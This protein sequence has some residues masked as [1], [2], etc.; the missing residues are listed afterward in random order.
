[1]EIVAII[2][3]RYGS[4]RFP[5]KALA[6]L[7][8]R[9]MIEHV[10][11]QV[12][13][14]EEIDRVIVATDDKRIYRAIEKCGGEAFLTSSEHQSGTDRISAVARKMECDLVI[15]VQ[16][17]EPLVDPGMIKEAFSPLLGNNEYVM[18]TLKKQIVDET[19]INDP[20]V[21]KVV[22]DKEDNALY[23]SRSPIPYPRQKGFNY[24]KHIG[25]YVYRR[26]FLLKYSQL[27]QTSLEK[28]ESLEQ[29]RALE[30]G[31]QIKVIETKYN[32]IGVDTPADLARV[33]KIMERGIYA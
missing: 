2:P 28:S 32:S 3:A 10:Y 5:G 27:E 15:N 21:V 31:Y 23:F 29:L 7:M 30:N 24:Y 33:E 17:D 14:V 25:L 4:T 20:N 18:S 13:K 22:A 19:E 11:K 9:P 12:R 1:M 26:N 6:E 8:G 16:G